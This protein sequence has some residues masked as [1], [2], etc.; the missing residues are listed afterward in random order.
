LSGDSVGLDA[1]LGLSFFISN[2]SSSKVSRGKKEGK[3][4]ESYLMM[5]CSL[6]VTRLEIQVAHL[7]QAPLLQKQLEMGNNRFL[8]N[9]PTMIFDRGLRVFANEVLV[10]KGGL[11]F[12]ELKLEWRVDFRDGLNSRGCSNIEAIGTSPALQ[13]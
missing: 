2:P 7:L 1:S 13:V 6:S 11:R 3:D 10:R 12:E 4:K 9:I 8:E 5:S